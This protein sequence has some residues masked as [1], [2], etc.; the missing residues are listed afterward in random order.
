MLTER[1][2]TQHTSSTP[3]SLELNAL[4]EKTNINAFL[5]EQV[6]AEFSSKHLQTLMWEVT[7]EGP[8]P[9]PKPIQTSTQQQAESGPYPENDY[10]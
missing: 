9:P 5:Q 1:Q 4:F 10:Q 7:S 8:I 6:I 2:P 3:I